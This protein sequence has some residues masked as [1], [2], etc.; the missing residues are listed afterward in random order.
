MCCLCQRHLCCHTYLLSYLLT[1]ILTIAYVLTFLLTVIIKYILTYCHTY[2]QLLSHM[3]IRI[4][5][6][7][8]IHKLS[9]N[10]YKYL[11]PLKQSLKK[12]FLQHPLLS[13]TE[14]SCGAKET[15][16]TE[17]SQKHACSGWRAPRHPK[18]A[19]VAPKYGM[20]SPFFH[21]SRRQGGTKGIDFHGNR[22]DAGE[23][24]GALKA[25]EHDGRIRFEEL[26]ACS[27]A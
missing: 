12:L 26:A 8:C 3:Y 20:I 17:K 23:D 6:C 1:V 15:H 22:G 18:R 13:T 7:S 11:H 25:G 5:Y 14:K 24:C 2:L 27:G 4:S 16:Y 10:L 19:H 21:V 9:T